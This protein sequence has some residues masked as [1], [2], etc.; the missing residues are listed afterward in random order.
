M[1]DDRVV[2]VD[3]RN[4]VFRNHFTHQG[5]QTTDGQPTSVLHGCL[6]GLLSLQKRLPETP[7]VFVWDG[8]GETW[9]HRLLK[10]SLSNTIQEQV[11]KKATENRW[12]DQQV[13]SSL[14]YVLGK[15]QKPKEEIVK[16][17]GYKANRYATMNAQGKEERERA[18]Q[19]I[20][21]LIEAMDKIGL[22][23]FK[24][25]GFEGDDLIGVLTTLILEKNLFYKVII[26]ST[27]KDF[28]QFIGDRV[29]VA[30]GMDGQNV[31]WASRDHIKFKYGVEV[32]N[33][34]K[35]RAITGDT[36]DNIPS[37]I[38]G[39]GPIT[40][41]K[42]IREGLD[43]S[44]RDYRDLPSNVR[45]KMSEWKAPKIGLINWVGLWNRLHTNYICSQIVRDAK[46]GLLE[47][48]VREKLVNL[49]QDMKTESFCRR[50]KG[51]TEDAY[52]E[53]TMWL[54]RK[55]LVELASK[56]DEFWK[57]R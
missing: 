36:S 11:E 53:F 2:L 6:S 47:D 31:V 38:T 16:V 35:Y 5:L 43:P 3:G 24:I 13:A 15:T 33:W 41:A 34:T 14:K 30:T 54:S 20:P 26:Y 40:A 56:R 52:R 29:K 23:N 9:R 1:M 17:V 32:E 44:I 19:Q 42:W 45:M 22:R 49:T 18:L 55:E 25:K 57:L 4:F 39:V 28:Y 48:G 10:P 21:E 37:F 27:D 7:I 12:I 46:F 50:S 51:Q 8:G